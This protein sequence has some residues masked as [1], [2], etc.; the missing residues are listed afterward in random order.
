MSTPRANAPKKPSGGRPLPKRLF[1]FDA[2]RKQTSGHDPD[3]ALANESTL[4]LIEKPSLDNNNEEEPLASSTTW[5]GK[6]PLSS[7]TE[8]L[9]PSRKTPPPA[10]ERF[11]A[12]RQGSKPALV[13]SEIANSTDLKAEV[14]GGKTPLSPSRYR[15]DTLRR[16]VLPSQDSLSEVPIVPSTPSDT[17]SIVS[18]ITPSRPS[19]PKSHRF[20]VGRKGMRQVVEEAR[21]ADFSRKVIE[22][23]RNACWA[24]RFG[25]MFQAPLRMERDPSQTS[26]PTLRNMPFIGSTA[27]LPFGSNASTTNLSGGQKNGLRQR[28]SIQSFAPTTTAMSQ[29]AMLLTRL[30]HR[31]T[32]LPI[33][34][35]VLAALLVPF[36]SPERCPQVEADQALA[37]EIFEFLTKSRR[38]SFTKDELE[39]CLW[40]FKAAS[41]QSKYRARIIGS[42]SYLVF[43]LERPFEADGPLILQTLYHGM[44]ALLFDLSLTPGT[45][46]EYQTLS[47]WIWKIRDGECGPLLH[48]DVEREYGVRFS[49]DDDDYAV[50]EAIMAE[51]VAKCLETGSERSRRWALRRLVQ[52]YWPVPESQLS[53]TPLLACIHWRKLKTFLSATLTLLSLNSDDGEESDDFIIIN[54]FRSRIIPEVEAMRTDV[55]ADIQCNVVRLVMEILCIRQGNH[56]E[57]F[58]MHLCDWYQNKPDWK[59]S[60]E[61][62]FSQLIEEAEW[63]LILRL[64]PTIAKEIPDEIQLP[65][66]SYIL[67]LLIE[68]LIADPVEIPCFALTDFLEAISRAYPKIFYKPL[69]TCAASSKEITVATQLQTLTVISKYIPDFWTRDPEMM[70]VALMSDTSK[71]LNN[72]TPT[73]GK[74]RLGQS[75]LL[76][77]LTEQLHLV[78]TSKDMSATVP[79]VKFASALEARLGI[80]IEAKEHTMLVSEPQRYLFCGLFREIRLLT[81]S[82]KSAPWLGS[83]I[84]WCA[85]WQASSHDE[86]R[87]LMYGDESEDVETAFNKLLAMYVHVQENSRASNKRRTVMVSTPLLDNS[88]TN[89]TEGKDTIPVFGGRLQ[90]LKSMLEAPRA[91]ALELLVAITGMLGPPEYTRL[92]PVLWNCCFD[93]DAR[94]LAPACFIIMQ[95]AERC[96]VEFTEVVN[97]GLESSDSI[98]RAETLEKISLL[99]SWR[100]QLLSQEVILDRSFRRPFKLTR[101]PILFVATDMGT[102][103]WVYEEDT[104]EWK[105]SHGN[106]LP[107]ELRK[108]LSEIGWDED[109]RQVD[110]KMQWIRTPMALL[111]SHQLEDLDRGAG[112]DF[113]FPEPPSPSHSPSPSPQAS[114]I[115]TSSSEPSLSRQDSTSSMRSV[116]VKRRPVFVSTLLSLLPQLAKMVSDRDFIVSSAAL[117]IILDLMR[118]DPGLVARGIFAMLSGNETTMITAISTLRAF[119]HVRHVLPPAMAHFILNHLTGFIKSLVKS[120]ESLVPLQSYAYSIPIIA[121]L[122]TQVSNLSMRELRR[123]KVD[124]FFVPTGSLWFPSTTIASA[125]FPRYL[126]DNHNPFEGIPAPLAWVTMIRIS[127]N[128]LFLSLL[129]RNPQDVQL[130][131]KN[132]TSL[133][134]PSLDG[135]GEDN[136]LLLN[137]LIPRR[138]DINRRPLT[139]GEIT[140][141]CLSLTLARS[142]LLLTG[143]VFQSLSRHLNDRAELSVWM[144]SISTILV[145]HGNDL[146]IVAHSMIVLMIAATRFRR[147]F[148]SGGGYTLFMPAVMKAYVEADRHPG[149]RNAIEYAASRFYALHQETFVF[150]TLDV[151]TPIIVSPGVD[152]AWIASCIHTLFAPLRGTVPSSAPDAAGIHGLNRTQEREA[153]MLTAADEVPQTFLASLRGS[154]PQEKAVINVPVPEEYESKRLGMDNLVRLLL[155]VIAYNPTA[156]RG[157]HFLRLLRLLAPDLYNASNSGRTVLR[158]GIVALSSI[159]L[160]KVVSKNKVVDDA[161]I[162]PAENFDTG[163]LGQGSTSS[164]SSKASDLLNMRLD[165]LALVL[166]YTKS[167]GTF[168]DTAHIRI[169]ELVKV[170]LKESRASV[171]QISSFVGDFAKYIFLRHEPPTP[172]H[173]ASLLT[174]LAPVISAY[175]TSVDFSALYDVIASLSANPKYSSDQSFANLVVIPY[176]RIGLDACDFMASEGV[177]MDFTLRHSLLVLLQSAVSLPGVDVMVELEKKT[178]S[179]EFLAG[180]VLPFALSLKNAADIMAA[181]DFTDAGRRDAHARTWLSLVTY[182]LAVCNAVDEQGK[183]GRKSS[184]SGARKGVED[185]YHTVMTFAMALQILK[186]IVIRAEDDISD[187]LPGIWTQMGIILRSSLSDGDASFALHFVDHSEPPSPTQSPRVSSFGEKQQNLSAFSSSISMHSRRALC[188]PRMIDY[189]AWSFIH[190]LW[191][192]RSPLMIEMR[193]FVQERIATLNEELTQRD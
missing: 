167:G 8:E 138:A 10:K 145:R 164:S 172:K 142:Y 35:E 61:N 45:E 77:E 85:H 69:F 127:Q 174:N 80:L 43:S 3:P 162:Q 79:A 112:E 21:V 176:C 5:L 132:A 190:W 135:S 37:I 102:S 175:S 48:E 156:Q 83:V 124:M 15:W 136:L 24:V 17:A 178:P 32:V 7:P 98:V 18:S 99:A 143:Q 52:Q 169:I 110:P 47:G 101:P 16:H 151:I 183:Q 189:L 87:T 146:G 177:L 54:I 171:Q 180:V 12:R 166:A 158:E 173:A 46:G 115:K 163:V 73:W 44:F 72:S 59:S 155:T 71:K 114:P 28:A 133:V 1:S 13:D 188:A 185:K 170:I 6:E 38:P 51:T 94:V 31:G 49:K 126:P 25:P 118:D 39:R 107:L 26:N 121:D 119:L 27:S 179:Y 95:A 150:Q 60:I 81:R 41:V 116:G 90:T 78:R 125:L 62:T 76:V 2:L 147:F 66:V 68:R 153:L 141:R 192:R 70:A 92:T 130:L 152:D 109:N 111:P 23:I 84:S 63:P 82:L 93:E 128:R 64:V 131:R 161:P 103:N 91:V 159:L 137:D 104:Q 106:V 160:T 34:N 134:L 67:P 120:T 58:L 129:R 97:V 157:E 53:L 168:S 19:T 144:D 75:V 29:L 123:N 22:E 89:S 56:K 88:R 86:D 50:R 14:S 149:I 100:F 55:A 57:Y 30:E 193:I 9:P 154:T 113:S 184:N 140:L 65:V 4:R 96:P 74:F 117:D 20:G 181:S 40:C 108:R 36:L 165:Y 42:L 33:E 105:D 186:I 191:L 182:T 139:S 148:T 187:A 122:F 11:R